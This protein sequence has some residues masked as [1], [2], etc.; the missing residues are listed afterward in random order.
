MFSVAHEALKNKSNLAK[1]ILMEHAPRFDEQSVDPIGLKPAL[2]NFANM[3]LNQLWKESPLRS[4]IIVAA[5]NLLCNNDD[6]R[7][8]RY[9][10]EKTKR[11][12]GVHLYGSFGKRAYTRSVANILIQAVTLSVSQ[13][14]HTQVS[15]KDDHVD[16]PQSRYRQ[17]GYSVPIQNKFDILGN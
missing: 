14:G 13:P 10:D 17:Q 9:T 15:N 1:V 6:T 2:A 8:A 16:C 11:Y 7:K 12:D 4:Q 5:H 3:T